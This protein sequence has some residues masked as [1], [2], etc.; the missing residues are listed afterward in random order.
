MIND[1]KLQMAGQQSTFARLQQMQAQPW[2]QQ[3]RPHGGGCGGGGGGGGYRLN[4]NRTGNGGGQQVVAGGGTGQPS[5]PFT[6]YEGRRFFHGRIRDSDWQCANCGFPTNWSCN[7]KC[8][9]CKGSKASSHLYVKER[10]TT[11]KLTTGTGSTAR[12]TTGEAT[13]VASGDGDLW[14]CR[15]LPLTAKSLAASAQRPPQSIAVVALSAGTAAGTAAAGVGGEVPTTEGDMEL[16]AHQ[17]AHLKAM[18]EYQDQLGALAREKLLSHNAAVLKKKAATDDGV[19]DLP[20]IEGCSP[21]Q[22]SSR[23]QEHL[24]KVRRHR[25]DVETRQATK[26]KERLED[27]QRREAALIKQIEAQKDLL[28]KAEEELKLHAA[29]VEKDSAQWV[30]HDAETL[31]VVDERARRVEAGLAKAEKARIAAGGAADLLVTPCAEALKVENGLKDGPAEAGGTNGNKGKDGDEEDQA[32][33]SHDLEE[34]PAA[35]KPYLEP[36][37]IAVKPEDEATLLHM[38]STMAQWRQQGVE[39]PLTLGALCLDAL[40]LKRIV[41]EAAWCEFYAGDAVPFADSA[42]DRRLLGILDTA[43]MKALLTLKT[44][45]AVRTAAQQAASKAVH[46]AA[47]AYSEKLRKKQAAG[48]PLGVKR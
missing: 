10:T 8:F 9:V 14:A 21:L 35:V 31:K 40:Q 22:A 12:A 26:K 46:G 11:C 24:S 38:F 39:F 16:P 3:L 37:T 47:T 33:T 17:I 45:G 6:L 15:E 48:K 36:P 20:K 25:A 32:M 30:I 44:D 41:G 5:R 4:G 2:T 28:E 23:L 1:I 7:D 13:A 42:L 27:Q 43:L 19:T 34:P 18:A 29:M